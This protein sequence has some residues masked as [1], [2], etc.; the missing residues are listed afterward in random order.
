MQTMQ[1]FCDD[2]TQHN[3]AVTLP[4]DLT[5]DLNTSSG[6]EFQSP[7][8]ITHKKGFQKYPLM[9]NGV[10]ASPVNYSPDTIDDMCLSGTMSPLRFSSPEPEIIDLTNP[11]ENLERRREIMWCCI[12]C[13]HYNSLTK[14]TCEK[15]QHHKDARCDLNEIYNLVD[16]SLVI[17]S[18]LIKA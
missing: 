7:Q 17:M 9:D 11:R 12:E 15:C 4:F 1:K 16:C 14:D 18:Y 6:E 3:Q 8:K 10:V 2:F 13:R 5:L